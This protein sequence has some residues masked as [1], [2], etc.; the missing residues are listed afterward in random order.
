MADLNGDG[1]ESIGEKLAGAVDG[2]SQGLKNLTGNKFDEQIDSVSDNIE[3]TIAEKLP[4]D[5][6][7]GSK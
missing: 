1:K 2:A 6:P 5:N 3:A 4:G 7:F